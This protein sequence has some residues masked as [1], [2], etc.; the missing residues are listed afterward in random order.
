MF[1]RK[2]DPHSAALTL[3]SA[4]EKLI[5]NGYTPCSML[6]PDASAPWYV[7][8]HPVAVR[9]LGQGGSLAALILTPPEDAALDERIRAVLERSG[10]TRGPLRVGSD[11]RDLWVLRC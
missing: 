5:A 10:K 6:A 2:N 11:A 1:E 7:S 3:G 8:E 9:T 4:R